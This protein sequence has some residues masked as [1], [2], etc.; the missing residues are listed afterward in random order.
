M[1]AKMFCVCAAFVVWISYLDHRTLAAEHVRCPRSCNCLGNMVDCSKKGLIDVPVDLPSWVTILDLNSNG[2]SALHEDDFKGLPNLEKLDLSDNDIKFINKSIFQNLPALLEIKINYNKLTELPM[3]SLNSTLNHLSLHHNQIMTVEPKALVTMP[4]LRFLDVNYNQ[5]MDLPI[6][7][8]PAGSKLK[9]LHLSN[10]RI[11]SLEVGC[12]DNLTALETL[13]L[14]KNKLFEV[15]KKVFA[16]LTSLKFLELMRNKIDKIE[17]LAFQGLTALQVLKLKRN[18][19][20]NMMAGSFW[21]LENI[22]NLQLDYNNITSVNKGWLYGLQSLHQLSLAHNNINNIEPEGLSF[23]ERL[24]KIDLSRNN[25]TSIDEKMFAGMTTLQDLLLNNNKISRIDIGAFQDLSSLSNLDLNFNEISWT[26]EDVRGAFYGLKN[27]NR[28]SLKANHIK[29][30]ASEAFTGLEKLRQLHLE[31]NNITGIQENSFAPLENLRDLRLN[32]TALLCDCQLAWLP[33]WLQRSGFHNSVKAV[34]SHPVNLK[35]KSIFSIQL[36]QFT[37]NDQEYPKPIIV[38]H[39]RSQIALKGDNLTLHCVSV[40][41]GDKPPKFQWKKD[42]MLLHHANVENRATTDGDVKR[43]T[44]LLHVF[45][46]QNDMAGRYQCVISSDFGST[47]SNK[48]DINVH[49]FPVFT[50]TPVDI[51]IKA[52]KTAKLE[53]SATGQPSPVMAWQKDGGDDFPAA[54][55]RRMHVMPQDDTFFIVNT[56]SSDEGVYSCTATNDAGTIAVNATVTIL[57]TPSFVQPMEAKKFFNVGKTSVLECMAAGSPKPKLS[58]LKD[59][60]PLIV[61]PRHFFSADNQLLIIVETQS[62]DSGMYMCEMSNT[63]GTQKGTTELKVIPAEAQPR[64]SNGGTFGLDDESTTTGIIIIA[65]VCCVVG[66]SLVWV[67]IIYQTRKRHEMYSSTPTDETTLPCELPSSGYTSSDKDGSFTQAQIAVPS[68]QY[69]IADYQMKESGYESSSGRFR[70]NG[71]VRPA[72]IFPSD[73][74]EDDRQSVPLTLGEQQPGRDSGGNSV[75]SL[76]YPHSETDTVGSSHSTSSTHSGIHHPL[77]T[78][79]PQLT[80]HDRCSPGE[81]CENNCEN[82]DNNRTLNG[83]VQRLSQQR[84][85]SISSIPSSRS[86]GLGL[87]EG[88]SGFRGHKLCSSPPSKPLNIAEIHDSSVCDCDGDVSSS[89]CSVPH[90]PHVHITCNHMERLHNAADLKHKLENS[91]HKLPNG[92]WQGHYPVGNAAHEPHLKQCPTNHAGVKVKSRD[93]TNNL[94][95]AIP[96]SQHHGSHNS[97]HNKKKNCSVVNV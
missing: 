9:E 20:S 36:D 61:T 11:L 10:N 22:K 18:V 97:S 17:G 37:C 62:S 56:K 51:T 26:I 29:S 92:T 34:C 89:R 50:K 86:S 88:E 43:Y 65:V 68:Y 32:T 83:S 80:N 64:D 19:I 30:I 87:P 59:G 5:L 49:V 55:E 4:N 39:P 46:I 71:W 78:F 31:D 82:S 40:I 52:G 2:I 79:H 96:V 14:N 3:F 63:L 33:T 60:E 76:H 81:E 77:R 45:N 27:L 35:G 8:F 16:N 57:E 95:T 93:A 24:H 70:A 15:Q 47:Y 94:Y 38:E 72:A 91:H 6:G 44:T 90:S 42:S 48:A 21:G 13:K 75:C 66:T 41:T 84:A 73:V 23:C 12:F 69:Q 25:L 74:D 7:T 58:W 85:P 53:C 28:L 54:R 1:A 67:I